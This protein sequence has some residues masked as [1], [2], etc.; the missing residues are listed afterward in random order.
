[1]ISYTAVV[2]P[3]SKDNLLLI[4]ASVRY[5]FLY[6]LGVSFIV[7]ILYLTYPFLLICSEPVIKVK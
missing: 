1:M 4:F 7:A 2:T 3:F 6:L 5:C